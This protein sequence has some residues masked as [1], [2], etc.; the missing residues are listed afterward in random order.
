MRCLFMMASGGS[1]DE[2]MGGGGG[3]L[4]GERASLVDNGRE[5]SCQGARLS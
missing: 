5:V 3:G 4:V 1:E 2:D